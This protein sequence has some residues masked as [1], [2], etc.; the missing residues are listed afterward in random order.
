MFDREYTLVVHPRLRAQVSYRGE[1]GIDAATVRLDYRR[2][3]EWTEAGTAVELP[4]APEAGTEWRGLH[5]SLFRDGERVVGREFTSTLLSDAIDVVDAVAEVAPGVVRRGRNAAERVTG[6]LGDGGA[7]MT[8]LDGSTVEALRPPAKATFEVYEGRDERWRWRLVHDNGNVI[9]DSGQG[10]ASRRGAE[11]GIRSVKRNALGAAV[12]PVGG[13][14][15]RDVRTSSDA[16]G[17]T[18]TDAG[19]GTGSAES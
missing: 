3:E 17:E 19:P 8:Q 5:V 2:D 6:R 1:D 10:Y 18:G 13:E 16:D 4:E 14:A 12:E 9:A 11:K 15:E 7:A